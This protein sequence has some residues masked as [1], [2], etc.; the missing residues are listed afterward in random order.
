MICNS[1]FF[2]WYNFIRDTIP[3]FELYDAD[4][5][6]DWVEKKVGKENTQ[7]VRIIR[8]IYLIS[9]IAEMY[10]GKFCTI[11]MKCPKLWQKMEELTEG[12]SSSC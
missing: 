12:L 6:A 5:E 9:E 11:K 2:V 4:E 1:N 7:N 10:A 3:L 8:T